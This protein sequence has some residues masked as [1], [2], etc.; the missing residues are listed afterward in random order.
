MEPNNEMYGG[1]PVAIICL[2]LCYFPN[3]CYTSRWQD[4]V[5]G[6]PIKLAVQSQLFRYSLVASIAASIPPLLDLLYH[7]IKM[8]TVVYNKCTD[9]YFS[10]LTVLFS[11]IVPE[12]MMLIFVTPKGNA[13]LFVCIYDSQL[14][15]SMLST[16]QFLY[17]YGKKYWRNKLF[18]AAVSSI[19]IGSSFQSLGPYFPSDLI[20]LAHYIG[21]LIQAIGVTIFQ[22]LSYK[23]LTR[24]GD[25]KNSEGSTV[26]SV[27]DESFCKYVL[28]CMLFVINGLVF[29]DFGVKLEYWIHYDSAVLVYIVFLLT[30]PTLSMCMIL[31]QATRNQVYF[32]Q[33]S[34]ILYRQKP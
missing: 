10:A 9:K 11:L 2:I 12:L 1:V 8:D 19:Y 14:I 4:A 27:D 28:Y 30:V 31:T 13:R 15:L 3:F 34:Y 24:P 7:I 29:L 21:F 17:H 16:S 25:G 5:D 18:T 20:I 6:D 23:Y 33:V 22:M 32:T 26:D